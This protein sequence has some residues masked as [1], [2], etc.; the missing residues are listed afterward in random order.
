MGAICDRDGKVACFSAAL[1]GRFVSN[2]SVG[3]V[4]ASKKEGVM[5]LPT[6]APTPVSLS[7]ETC[8]DS[9]HDVHGGA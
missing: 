7:W 8:V 1:P 6:L 2:E 9:P 5:Q 3:A 4:I